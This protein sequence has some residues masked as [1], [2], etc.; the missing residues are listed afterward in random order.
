MSHPL[1]TGLP[2]NFTTTTTMGASDG[3]IVNGGSSIASCSAC[4][5][6]G[7][8]VRSGSGG[9]LV[10]LV[11][12]ANYNGNSTWPNDTNTVNLTINAIKWAT[13]CLL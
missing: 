5:S 9:R 13:G 4:G 7:V 6:T 8:I 12:A 3:N 10:Y 11:H 1:W 2:T